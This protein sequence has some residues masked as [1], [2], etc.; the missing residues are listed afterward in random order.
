[1]PSDGTPWKEGS[2]LLQ[3]VLQLLL[4][5]RQHAS[6]LVQSVSNSGKFLPARQGDCARN[7][8]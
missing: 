4:A 8:C 5:P 6:E 7:R 1:M 3:C 2:N